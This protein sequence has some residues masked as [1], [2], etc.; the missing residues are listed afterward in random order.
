MRKTQKRRIQTQKRNKIKRQNIK[1]IKSKNNKS[2]NNKNKKTQKAGYYLYL[3]KPEVILDKF[4]KYYFK[5]SFE[6]E[7]CVKLINKL[8]EEELETQKKITI[9]LY[10]LK[11][12]LTKANVEFEDNRI[13]INAE[14]KKVTTNLTKTDI[15]V[16]S[17]DLI[18]DFMRYY[19]K[20]I[21]GQDYTLRTKYD[22][23][24]SLQKKEKS[25]L[26][27]SLRL[28]KSELDDFFPFIG[29]EESL[30]SVAAIQEAE[31]MQPSYEDVDVLME[32]N[33]RLYNQQ[34]SMRTR[35]SLEEDDDDDQDEFKTAYGDEENPNV[36][37]EVEREIER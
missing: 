18:E 3:D 20:K 7:T 19:Y 13:I 37:E 10:I 4:F 22:G 21:I 11:N 29:I 33:N 17:V 9:L 6:K 8:K 27:Q 12:C 25:V 26:E 28:L 31:E 24:V 30:Q 5:K 16:F 15:K 36:E 1:Y 34:D 32:P 23:Y 2:K 14:E 35:Y